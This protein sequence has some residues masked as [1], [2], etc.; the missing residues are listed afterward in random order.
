MQITILKDEKNDLELNLDNLT[1]AE[2]LRAYL[3]NKE[4]VE[5]AAWKREHPS[6]APILK[7]KT[8]GKPAKR[9]LEEAIEEIEKELDKIESEFKKSK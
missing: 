1:I 3:A 8:K 2:L 5:M 9:I 7:I 4:N 6:K